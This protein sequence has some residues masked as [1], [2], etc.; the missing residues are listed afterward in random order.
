MCKFWFELLDPTGEE[1]T[2][3]YYTLSQETLTYLSIKY[4]LHELC[5]RGGHNALFSKYDYVGK[6]I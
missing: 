3:G 4:G 5:N 1:L 2:W 6:W